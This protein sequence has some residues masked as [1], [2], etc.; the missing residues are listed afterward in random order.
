MALTK[1]TYSMILGAPAN[2]LDFGADPTGA[3][4]SAASI[5][6]AMDA[7]KSV[8]FPAGTYLVQTKLVPTQVWKQLSVV[9]QCQFGT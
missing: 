9:D 3:A 6:A 2:V 5:Q 1:A 7:S 8:Y 4:N